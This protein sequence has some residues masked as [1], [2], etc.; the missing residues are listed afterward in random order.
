MIKDR[1]VA[2][3]FTR[4]NDSLPACQKGNKRVHRADDQQLEHKIDQR[5][6]YRVRVPVDVDENINGIR[7]T[8]E[9][10]EPAD[11]ACGYEK[12]TDP[13]KPGKIHSALV[14]KCIND[15]DK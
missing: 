1:K 4:S 6:A 5:V 8:A 7:Q 2:L 10:E 11:E 9:Q 12:Q 13:F 14:L 3:F 15:E